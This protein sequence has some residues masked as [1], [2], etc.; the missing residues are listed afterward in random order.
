[1]GNVIEVKVAKSIPQLDQAAIEAAMEFK[2]KPATTN[3][4]RV[5]SWL[6]IPFHFKLSDDK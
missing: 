6:T 1:L 4:K 3:E 5:K 2:F